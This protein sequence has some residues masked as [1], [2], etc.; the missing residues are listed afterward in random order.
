MKSWILLDNE[1]TTDISV[2]SKYLTNIK[3]VPTTLKLMNNGGLL[4]T[5][6]QGNL[7]NYCNVCY[8][9]KAISNIQSLGNTNK[10][11]CSI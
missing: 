9:S 5:N 10:K 3:T 2:E 1:S 7:E 8:H 11:N 4:T 6:Q